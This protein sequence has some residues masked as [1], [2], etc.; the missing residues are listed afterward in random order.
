[1]R[2]LKR[3]LTACFALAL[4]VSVLAQFNDAWANKPAHAR[5][6]LHAA[7][8]KNLKPAAAQKEGFCGDVY[9]RPS[10]ALLLAAP[11]LFENVKAVYIAAHGPL[12]GPVYDNPA[13]KVGN[14]AAAAGCILHKN[15]K[16]PKTY[17]FQDVYSLFST[18]AANEDGNLIVLIDAALQE[19]MPGKETAKQPAKKP[20]SPVGLPVVM[21][22][23]FYRHDIHDVQTQYASD[24]ARAFVY[25]S[26]PSVL[27]A[28]IK[29]ALESCLVNPFWM[30]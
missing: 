13:F 24:C 30:K 4:L 6:R 15:F 22:V 20:R 1:M 10:D 26:K 3:L 17:F 12:P 7:A 23:S 25:P 27:Q 11:P 9:R 14:L 5:P 28:R 18:N 2:T 16:F 21:H 19:P 29:T 8:A